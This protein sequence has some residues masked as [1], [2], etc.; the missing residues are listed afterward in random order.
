[1]VVQG[2]FHFVGSRQS[3]PPLVISTARYDLWHWTH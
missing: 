1:L 3:A 2:L